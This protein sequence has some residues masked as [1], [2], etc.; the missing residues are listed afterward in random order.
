MTKYPRLGALNN[1]GLF[2]TVLEAAKI[3]ALEGVWWG[4]A[5]W[6]IDGY[7]FAVSS[8]D[9]RGKGTL[10]SPIIR[11]LSPFMRVPPLWPKYLPRALPPKTIPLGVIISTYKSC[12]LGDK[13]IQSIAVVPNLF[14]MRAPSHGRIFPWI[15]DRMVW[16]WFK[17]IIFIMH[18]IPILW[19]S[20]DIPSWF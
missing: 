7:L 15:G 18:F 11:A 9:R 13:S 3:K 14:D 1:R 10:W 16:G 5:S 19:N 12:T 8:N 17:C 4:P 6:F 2:L 20:Q